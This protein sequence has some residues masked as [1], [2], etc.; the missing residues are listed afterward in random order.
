ME[1]MKHTIHRLLSLLLVLALLICAVPAVFAEEGGEGHNVTYTPS[2]TVG[3]HTVACEQEN[4]ETHKRQEESC[5][6]EKNNEDSSE[7]KDGKCDLCGAP[8]PDTIV[9]WKEYQSS[10]ANPAYEY[11]FPA[12]EM[13]T[14][15]LRGW[16]LGKI[17]GVTAKSEEVPDFEVTWTPEGNEVNGETAGNYKYTGE[18][19]IPEGKYHTAGNTITITFN[20]TAKTT[21]TIDP[22]TI[23]LTAKNN[24]ITVG[25]STTLTA[26]LTIPTGAT[27]A[28]A[29]WSVN[30]KIA[31]L[32]TGSVK[33]KTYTNTLKALD[34]GKV[35]VT[36]TAKV[37]MPEGYE[38]AEVTVSSNV[39]IEIAEKY[40]PKPD[41]IPTVSI[42][43]YMDGDEVLTFDE[44]D[45]RSALRSV[46]SKY[47][48][49]DYVL[50]DMD[51][52][53]FGTSYGGS[54]KYGYLYTDSYCNTKLTGKND[55][56][57]F[58]YNAGRGQYDLDDVTYVPGTASGKYTVSIPYT[59][60]ATDSSYYYGYKAVYGVV[61]IV[62]NG[63]DYYTISPIG[64]DLEGLG[65]DILSL[66]PRA[67]HVVFSQP[68]NGTLYY[69]YTAI[70]N[71]GRL[72][73]SNDVYA[74]KYTRGEYDVDDVTLIPAAG[75]TKVTVYFDVYSGNTKLES[76]YATFAVKGRSSSAAFYD[77]TATNTGT[78]SAD[79]IDFMYANGLIKGVG[80]SKFSPNASMKRADLVVI[81]YRL[82]GSPSV[83][84][85]ENP[86]KDVKSSDYYYNAVLWAYANDVVKGSGKYFNPNAAITR[87]Q[88]ATILYRYAGKPYTSARLGSYTDSGKVSAYALDAMKWAVGSGVVNGA[89]S[90]LD[91]QGN[92]TRAQVATMLHRYLTK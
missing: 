31:S 18:V 75:A 17:T 10:E 29:T 56:T 34:D 23:K 66:Y 13:S 54:S 15:T 14:E 67:T 89:G 28:S 85:V 24:K 2:A 37:K 90:K 86:F 88:L 73:R 63:V 46:Y 77:V 83:K 47:V 52:A 50:F 21:P 72:V 38:P 25:D 78:W 4:C 92:A 8:M 48:D 32:G 70:N 22:P 65:S 79:S 49:L 36:F 55:S 20:I 44:D 84:Y 6:D 62:V 1:I 64:T 7:G 91:P 76:T 40:I 30:S 71:Y 51:N 81:L 35:T 68:T 42:R 74:L 43:Y 39:T 3:K 26:D 12:G 61:E 27:V 45:F 57:K 80:G 11:T 5:T 82:A 59:A 16:M 58:Y 41:P 9:Y 69:D 60:Y 19:E 53:Y 87:E 33:D